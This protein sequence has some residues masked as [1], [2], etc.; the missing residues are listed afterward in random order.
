MRALLLAAVL[1]ASCGAAAAQPAPAIVPAPAGAQADPGVKTWQVLSAVA[2]LAIL[3]GVGFALVHY[4]RR[5]SGWRGIK[6]DDTGLRAL[7]TARLSPSVT[8]T[9]MD[10]EGRRVLVASSA[11]GTSMIELSR[12]E[13]RE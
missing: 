4:V 11:T 13:P 1:A 3:A 9:L 12:T 7:G 5:G 6:G 8:V 2:Y 10:V